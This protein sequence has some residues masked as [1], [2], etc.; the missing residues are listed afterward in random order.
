M[1][2]TY[3]ASLDKLSKIVTTV[4]LLVCVVLFFMFWQNLPTPGWERWGAYIAFGSIAAVLALTYLLSPRAYRLT[5]DTLV[6]ERR[7]KPITIALVDIEAFSTPDL[8]DFTAMIRLFGSGG[9]WGYFGL[10]WNRRIGRM[11][12]YATQLHNLVMLKVKNSH[13]I[14]LTPDDPNF[15]LQLQTNINRQKN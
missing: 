10:F 4:V 3:T 7:W 2:T 15:M 1:E 11:Y 14:V 9:L 12:W 6:I 13:P 5:Q 8:K